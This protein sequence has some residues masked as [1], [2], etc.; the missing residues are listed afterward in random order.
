MQLVELKCPG[1]GSQM[2]VS[3]DRTQVVCPFCSTS[4]LIDD[5]T[6][7]VLYDNAEQA[8]YDFEMGRLRAREEA[9]ADEPRQYVVSLE[10]PDSYQVAAPR[11]RRTWLW[12]LGWIFI[13]PVPA[14]ILIS[15]RDWNIVT[16]TFLIILVWIAYLAIA[17]RGSSS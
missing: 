9:G 7:H 10:Y 13:F 12:V 3:A 6:R 8:G 2:A 11:R 4:A 15:R 17:S 1:C 5:G 16:K 14:T